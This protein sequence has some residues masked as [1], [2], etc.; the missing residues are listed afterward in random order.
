MAKFDKKLGSILLG[1]ELLNEASLVR[2]MEMANGEEKS[3][4]QVV[5]EHGMVDERAFIGSVALEMNIPP[6]DLSRTVAS[7]EALACLPQDM[8]HYYG[9]LPVAKIGNVLT[10][11]VA[12]PFDILKLDDV[13]IITG[14]DIRP[15]VSTEVSIRKAIEK[16]YNRGEAEMEQ[17]FED[18]GDPEM[19]FK[20]A[21]EEEDDVDLTELTGS[22]ESS[23]VVKL[24][25]LLI[26]QAVRDGASDIHIE[27][28]E[29]KIRVR[30]RQDG[31]LRETISP[32]KAMQSAMVSRVK[33]MADLD[34]AEK[35]R[36]Q[37]GK[38]QIRLDG[39]NID[40]RVSI[41]PTIH[42]EKVVLR[43]LDS[44]N[45]A[46]SLDSLGFEQKALQDFRKAISSPYGMIL[47]TGPT[48]S[49]KSTTLYSALREM[50]NIEDNVITVEDPVEYQ[51]DGVN[52]VPVNVKRGLTFAAAL[53]SILRQDPDT[54]MVGEIRDKE[55]VEIAV[56][57][58]LT[59]HLV[60]STLHTNDAP[61]TITRML[62]MGVDPFMVASSTVLVS[63]QRLARK[64]CEECREETEIKDEALLKLGAFEDDLEDG[65][66][67]YRPVGCARCVN[68]YRG[69]F[70]LLE[71]MPVT[72]DLK[73]IIID[74][75]SVLALKQQALETG[76]VTLRRCGVINAAR[77]KTSLEEV[78]QV[79][80][81]D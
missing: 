41:L 34:I 78:V 67:I 44:G 56:K 66:R 31:I 69:R 17:L 68:G 61:S 77:G 9:V 24:V 21:E 22:S 14:S 47:V 40:F 35:R 13:Q 32:P 30:Y 76:M 80:M 18:M 33:I 48:G 38:F 43:I 64:L 28:F 70:A 11:A 46:L 2:A 12:N 60:L 8:A 74:G 73:R 16:S 75:G 59:G 54:V 19:E 39:R 49:G 37:D 3:L 25:N 27:P 50:M 45:L 26:Y 72:D 55:T 6:I 53:R 10:M 20:G 71:T 4:A 62:D 52:Q 29:K 36:P 1:A 15:V 79:T 7:D 5:I 57:A 63:A 51:L 58:A 42:G 23:P 65:A 81:A